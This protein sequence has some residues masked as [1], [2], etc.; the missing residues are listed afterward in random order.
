MTKEVCIGGDFVPWATGACSWGEPE[1]RARDSRQIEQSS[2][3]G[4]SAGARV[5]VKVA[6]AWMSIGLDTVI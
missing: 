5:L 4:I 1:S 6:R 3:W 2:P